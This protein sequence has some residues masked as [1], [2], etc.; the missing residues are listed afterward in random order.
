MKSEIGPAL[1]HRLSELVSARLGLRFP[2]DRFSDLQRGLRSAAIEFEFSESAEFASWLLETELSRKQ[3]ET[4]ASHLTIGETY[5]FREK[6]AFEFVR[7]RI[8]PDLLAHRRGQ[9]QRL[10]IWSAGCCSGEEPYSIAMMLADYLPDLAAWDISILA[11]DINPSF[12]RRA[13]QGIYSE[14]SFRGVAP[15]IRERFFSRLSDARYQIKPNIRAMVRFESLNLAE[16]AYPSL[17]NDTSSVDILFCRNVLIYMDENHVRQT[18]GALSRSLA[19]GGWLL[20]SATELSLV[21]APELSSEQAVGSM[22]FQ[23]RAATTDVRPLPMTFSIPEP[24]FQPAWTSEPIAT[25]QPVIR[26]EEAPTA[27]PVDSPEPT[28]LAKTLAD[29]GKL[30]E[31]IA[32]CDRAAKLDKLNPAIHFLRANILLE[33]GD[34]TEAVSALQTAT[35]LDP[36]F[37]MAYFTLGQVARLRGSDAEARRHFANASRLLAKFKTDQI[38]PESEGMTAGRLSESI[39]MWLNRKVIA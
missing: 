10:R 4:L 33:L 35:Y 26:S 2:P 22:A 36:E 14:W 31:A 5:F 15:S 19:L 18:I 6:Q 30:A 17:L 28:D 16:D 20:V 32:A 7:Q 24:T 25:P 34:M 9:E 37:V 39:A 12:L 27:A 1:L 13:R 38:V 23:K 21:Q 3:I 29:E 11:T 8:L